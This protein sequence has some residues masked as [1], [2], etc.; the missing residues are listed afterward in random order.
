[1]SVIKSKSWVDI[2]RPPTREGYIFQNDSHKSAFTKFIENKD[3]PHLMLAGGPGSGKTT[4]S[5]IIINELDIHEFDIL[6][7]N[8]SSE[9]GADTIRNKI[10]DFASTMPYGDRFKIIQLEEFDRLTVAAQEIL[11][12]VMDDTTD[13]CR[14]IA[15]CNNA[16]KIIAPMKSRFQEFYFKAPDKED[17]LIKICEIML[18]E[19]V[20]FD[21]DIAQH[22]VD[23]SYPDIRKIIQNCQLNSATGTL[24]SAQVEDNGSDD[25]LHSI[26][27]AMTSG[28]FNDIR[29]IIINKVQPDHY[30]EIYR[31]VYQNLDKLPNIGKDFDKQTSALLAL[32]DA[33]YKH[34]I[35]AIPE[36][37]M[38]VC[39]SIIK[40]L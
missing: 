5:N 20:D 22:Y 7:I 8:A 2:Y 18:E 28:S 40:G 11:R 23:V 31:F 25:Y 17:V 35:V 9:N 32:N 24:K 19:N 13:T 26:L 4:M 34:R 14:F 29:Q 27:T 12:V 37:N 21:M 33:Q 3:I 15:T 39:L 38:E 36:L 30:D 6:R 16:H 10:T 1:M